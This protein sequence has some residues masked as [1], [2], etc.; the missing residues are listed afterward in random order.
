MIFMGSCQQNAIKTQTLSK[1]V[2]INEMIIIVML[3]TLCIKINQVNLTSLTGTSRYS[4]SSQ[5]HISK[6]KFLGTSGS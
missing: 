1:H 4:N 6:R 3:A 5:K 2:D